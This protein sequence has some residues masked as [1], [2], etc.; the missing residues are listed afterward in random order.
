M[1][2]IDISRITTKYPNLKPDN[3]V[4]HI[5]LDVSHNLSAFE[6]VVDS[7][8]EN[9]K[10]CKIKIVCGFS[11]MK[12]IHSMLEFMVKFSHKIYFIV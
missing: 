12:D 7:L 4:Q 2:K 5:Y 1:E 11:K 8:K 6:A 9:H 3:T 10:D